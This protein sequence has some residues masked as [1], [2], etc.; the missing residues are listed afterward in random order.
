MHFNFNLTD[1]KE[2]KFHV[3]Y[4]FPQQQSNSAENQGGSISFGWAKQ[5][6]YPYNYLPYYYS[7]PAKK[8]GIHV[9]IPFQQNTA[10]EEGFKARL[11]QQQSYYPLSWPLKGEMDAK[12]QR[13]VY[14]FPQEKQSSSKQQGFYNWPQ[15]QG[16]TVPFGKEQGISISWP[17]K[18]EINAEE[19][20]IR[21][22]YGWPQEQGYKIGYSKEQGFATKAKNFARKYLYYLNFFTHLLHIC[23]QVFSVML[24]MAMEKLQKSLPMLKW[25]KSLLKNLW[26]P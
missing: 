18:K 23:I 16:V 10:N 14:T 21:F 5:Q 9:T 26:T 4:G 1:A 24:R 7:Q 20:G 13:L 22:S 12:Q 17:Q 2:Q 25:M 6:R 8:E 19:Q 11:P 15:Q 3:S